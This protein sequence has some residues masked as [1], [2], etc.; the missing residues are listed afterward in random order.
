[1]TEQKF[2]VEMTNLR[3]GE[4]WIVSVFGEDPVAALQKVVRRR[5]FVEVL[6]SEDPHTFVVRDYLT[7][8]Y[9]SSV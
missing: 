3:T 1:M 5:R 6:L 7:L 9:A 8:G 2:E 4:Q